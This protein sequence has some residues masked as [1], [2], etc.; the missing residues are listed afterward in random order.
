MGLQNID[1][2]DNTNE[3]YQDLDLIVLGSDV[4]EYQKYKENVQKEFSHLSNDAYKSMRLR[5][6]KH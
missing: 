2:N 1:Q 3:M 5:V 6:N 4:S